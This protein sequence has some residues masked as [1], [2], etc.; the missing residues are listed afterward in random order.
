MEFRLQTKCQCCDRPLLLAEKAVEGM[1]V[2]MVF[3]K[4]CFEQ[5]DFLTLR[6]WYKL[7][8]VIKAMQ[9]NAVQKAA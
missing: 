1:T 3:C 5:Y 6:Q 8:A 2:A 4:S 9:T 7:D